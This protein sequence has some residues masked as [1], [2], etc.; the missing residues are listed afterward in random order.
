MR[1][2]KLFFGLSLGIILFFFVA[3]VAL[4]A[5]IIAAVMSLTYAI[6]RR[7]KDFI[8]YDRYGNHY[9]PEYQAMPRRHAMNQPIEPLFY[10]TSYRQ[11]SP[12]RNV[13]FIDAI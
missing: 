6:Y 11:R 7:L 5:F 10:E 8:T 12:A 9:I 3:R 1:P 4:L 13:Q 2:F